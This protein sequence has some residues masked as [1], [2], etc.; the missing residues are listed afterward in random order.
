LRYAVGVTNIRFSTIAICLLGLSAS[1]W[2]QVAAPGEAGVSMGHVHFYSK[3][4][5]A[6]KKFWVEIMGAQDLQVEGF[7]VFKMPGVL[8]VVSKGERAG[9][10]EGSV[11]NH[12]AVKVKDLA[13]TLGKLEAAHVTIVSRNPPQAM[14]LGPDDVRVELTEDTGLATPLAFHHIHYYT[15]NVDEM[16]KWYVATFGAIPGKRGRFEAADLP[17]VNLTFAPATGALVGTKGRV[18]DHIGF[19][20]RGLEAFTKKLEAGGTKFDVTY[21]Q[22]PALGI[23]IA[24]LTDPWGTYI[25]LTEGLN[26]L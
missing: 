4:T 15:A 12:I 24:F 5:D 1:G 26:K 3:D 11:V 8:I 22:V 21:R 13:A 20:V 10:T 19:E 17:G 14:V 18:L 16:K 2:G 25:E 9:G 7:S 6:H 23:A